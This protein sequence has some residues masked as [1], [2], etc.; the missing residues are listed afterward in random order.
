VG[1]GGRGGRL[2]GFGA[3]VM[4]DNLGGADNPVVAFIIRV[5]ISQ[6]C[7]FIPALYPQ[8][9]TEESPAPP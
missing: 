1:G 8:N 7:E 3:G 9:Q 2:A 5:G 4:Q 6:V